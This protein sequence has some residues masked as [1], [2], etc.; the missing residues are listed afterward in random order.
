MNSKVISDIVKEWCE[1]HSRP[2]G[3]EQLAR[4]LAGRY[5]ISIGY[6]D[7]RDDLERSK[8]AGVIKEPSFE[9]YEISEGGVSC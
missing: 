3:F 8:D 6:E 4:I 9:M 7:L 2:I 1:M 5:G